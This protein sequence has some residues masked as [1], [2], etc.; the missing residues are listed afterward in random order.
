M[1]EISRALT[2][3]YEEDVEDTTTTLS[4]DEDEDENELEIDMSKDDLNKLLGFTVKYI[5]DRNVD[6][7]VRE[8]RKEELAIVAGAIARARDAADDSDDSMG[9]IKLDDKS[10]REKLDV[11]MAHLEK[12]NLDS[13]D[14]IEIGDEIELSSAQ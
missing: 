6:V 7:R 2:E 3:Q 1:E 14:L 13:D 4:T 12:T 11:V 9:R 10:D 8:D 5:E